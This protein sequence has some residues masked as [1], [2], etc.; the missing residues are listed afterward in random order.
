MEFIV[1]LLTSDVRISGCILIAAMGLVFSAR[2]GVVN[3][4]VEGVMLLGAFAGY[5][6]SYFFGGPW[7]GLFVAA[8]VGLIIGMLFAFLVV[9]VRVDQTIVGTALNILGIGVSTTLYRLIFG[10]NAALPEVKT[11]DVLEIPVLSDIPYIGGILFKHNV[12][13]Y[14]AWVLVIVSHFVMFKTELGLK[15]RAVGE[16]PRACDTLGINVYYVRYGTILYSTMLGSIAGA[17]MSMAQLSVFT[18]EMIAG[19]GF[20]ALAAVVFGKWKPMG[21]FLAVMVFAL[22]D[23]LQL[24]LRA[25]DTAFPYEFLL[26]L[27]YVLT[28]FALMGIVGKDKSAGPAATGKP[29]VKE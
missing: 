14:L 10:I 8:V 6:G 1:N 12:L 7:R 4:G 2:S 28:I 11:F 20:M 15:I 23:A 13:L 5:A 22:G 26:M 19:R 29:Y 16:N 21:V 3:L 27:P 9:T 24:R 18:E 17:Y 25:L